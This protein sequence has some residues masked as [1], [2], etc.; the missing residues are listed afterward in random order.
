[1]KAKGVTGDSQ[2][3]FTFIEVMFATIILGIGLLTIGASFGQGLRILEQG[4]VK[5]I[6]KEKIAA[7]RDRITADWD[8]SRTAPVDSDQMVTEIIN[9]PNGK[10]LDLSTMGFRKIVTVTSSGNMRYVIITIQYTV[11]G[12]THRIR[13]NVSLGKG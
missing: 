2:S 12:R 7:E 13:G 9:L 5:L 4:P 1:M 11:G 6:V 8:N 3:G 10:T